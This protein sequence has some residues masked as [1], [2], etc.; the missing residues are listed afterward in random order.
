MAT[1]LFEANKILQGIP[2]APVPP[3]SVVFAGSVAY[4]AL[5]LGGR[6]FMKNRP[7]IKPTALL[8]IHNGAL[9]VY[10]GLSFAAMCASVA[11][12]LPYSSV[13]EAICDP[14]N[15]LFE[16]ANSWL[17]FIFLLSKAYEFLDTAFLIIQKSRLRFL[18]VYHHAVTLVLGWVLYRDEW[19][20]GWI[21]GA[22]NM[23]VHF[24]MY[25]YYSKAACGGNCW[26][27][28]Y[29]TTFQIVQFVGC[30]CLMLVDVITRAAGGRCPNGKPLAWSTVA[31]SLSTYASFLALFIKLYIENYMSAKATASAGKCETK[32]ND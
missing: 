6:E 19:T 30:L 2:K 22:W 15:F 25:Y 3:P 1:W 24:P 9:C 7:A 5:V 31:W 4:L 13:S 27:K 18:H 26:W 14:K 17:L 32:K 10:S 21:A 23:L 16:G 11:M 28:K 12:F 29:L 8:A 20:I